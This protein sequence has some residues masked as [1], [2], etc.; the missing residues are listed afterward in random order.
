MALAGPA[1][2][3]SPNVVISQAY[4]GGGNAGAQY[5]NDFVELFNRGSAPV[6]ISTWS[7]PIGCGGFLGGLH[8]A[9]SIRAGAY[10]ADVDPS[11]PSYVVPGTSS[12]ADTSGVMREA[13]GQYMYNLGVPSNASTAQL[14]TVLIR[15]FGGSAPTLYAV[16]KIR[17]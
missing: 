12:S 4:G 9:I 15:P 7:L 17:R 16:L 8:P 11:D 3:A 5:T 2:A 6:D 10:D 1:G 13:E 14:Y